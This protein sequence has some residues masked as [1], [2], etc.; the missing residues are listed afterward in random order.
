M[1]I[2]FLFICGEVFYINIGNCYN[3]KLFFQKRNFIAFKKINFFKKK[4]AAG[5][6]KA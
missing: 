3:R 6:K 2:S 4:G 1:K 5:L